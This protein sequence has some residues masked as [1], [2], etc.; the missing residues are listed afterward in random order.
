MSVLSDTPGPR[1][2]DGT[3]VCTWALVLTKHFLAGLCKKLRNTQTGNIA[4]F[5]GK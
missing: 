5:Q 1:E 4:L 3:P 2:K